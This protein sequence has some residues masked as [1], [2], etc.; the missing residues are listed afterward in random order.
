[1]KTIFSFT[2]L[3]VFF[4]SGLF[5]DENWLTYYEQ[6]NFQKTPRYAETIQFC[7][8]LAEASPMVTYRSFGHSPQG[9]EL[10]LLIVDRDGLNTPEAVRKAE[11]TILFVEAGIHAGEIDGKDAGLMLIRDLA[12]YQ[13][14]LELLNGV[15]L[16]FI[17][18]F[19]VD[20][21]ERFGPYNRI[22]QNGPQEMGWRVT[23]QNLNLNRD[24]L[25]ADAPEMQAWLRMFHRWLPD[26]LV[27]VHVTDGADYQYV[28]T[29]GVETGPHVALPLRTFTTDTL[30]PFL[31]QA[32]E[33]D[34]FPMF[35]YIM[36]RDWSNV[37]SG[38]RAGAASPRFSTGYGAVQNRIFYL[39]ETHMLKDYHTRVTAT[40][41]LL[42]H[43]L[44]FASRYGKM[45][46]R[47]NR[48]SDALTAQHL[49]GTFLPVR[50]SP[51]YQDSVM[52]DFLGV[53]FETVPSE[54]SGGNWVIYHSDRP[55]TYRL[56]YFNTL[57]VIDSVQVPYAYLIPREWQLQISRLQL[58]GVKLYRLQR[59]T[60][61]NVA[62]Y[63]FHHPRWRQTPYEGHHP[64][65][66]EVEP[67]TERRFYP[68]GTVVVPLNQRTNRVIVNLLEPR[69]PD[70]F[71]AWDFWDVIFER[72]EYAEMY[73]LEKMAREMLR[74]DPE[75]K[76]EFEAK[77]ASDSTFA[78]S[79]Y[80]RLYFFYRRSPYWDRQ[81]DLY[82][83]GKLMQPCALPMEEIKEENALAK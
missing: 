11:R 55:K 52:V 50:V 39:V 73:V 45:L 38:L 66:F 31:N 35:P 17:P 4:A 7:R 12:I 25:K 26:L 44:E 72:K 62:S 27:D 67:I 47:V 79:P 71:I 13:Q 57:K 9:R 15:T 22:N 76:K 61:L 24:F 70:S 33:R 18:I 82:P 10:P 6:S 46:Q 1:M 68:A 16:L 5:A 8:R 40:Y 83:V 37:L 48:R 75:L 29:Y 23:A 59:D 74:S 53:E 30:V 80:Q 14:N 60:T 19:N 32:M 34:G 41:H 64:V 28:V 54:I 2:L 69:A 36:F 3:L 51:S 65:S 21:H 78:R 42:H 81:K 56:P 58:H 77:I 63:R 49:A 20:G 43:F